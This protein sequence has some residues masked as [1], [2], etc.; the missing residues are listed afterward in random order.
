M[1][2]GIA[3]GKPNYDEMKPFL[4]EATKLQL[5]GMQAGISAL[6]P[7]KSLTF[8]NVTGQGHDLYLATYEKGTLA[9]RISMAPDGKVANAL[10]TP[11]Y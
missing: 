3:S 1:S 5:A 7:L 2:D 6:G 11:D 8:R 4:A 9:W 10:V